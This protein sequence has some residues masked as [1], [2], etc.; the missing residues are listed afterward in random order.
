[1][2]QPLSQL[3]R[4]SS[5]VAENDFL[6]AVP[7]NGHFENDRYY[8]RNES[9]Q[10]IRTGAMP[11][12]MTELRLRLVGL[13]SGAYTLEIGIYTGRFIVFSA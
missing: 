9:G 7:N 3:C 12:E 11:N 6:T 13:R 1:M 4:Y 10:I 8:I 5:Q 2:I